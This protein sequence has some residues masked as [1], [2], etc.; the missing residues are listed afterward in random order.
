MRFRGSRGS[1]ANGWSLP[2]DAVA[3]LAVGA[4]IFQQNIP[5]IRDHTHL[6]T[7]TK[8]NHLLTVTKTTIDYR[9]KYV[10]YA[11]DTLLERT[12]ENTQG[13]NSIAVILTTIVLHI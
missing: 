2:L 10:A 12:R 11:E 3:D 6:A 7:A 9:L 13:G 5:K 1:R 8:L 4:Y